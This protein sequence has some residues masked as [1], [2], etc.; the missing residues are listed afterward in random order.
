MTVSPP[1]N[2]PVV[3]RTRGE[4]EAL[5]RPRR[6]SG[7]RIGLVP[8][9]GALHVGHVA[10]FDEARAGCDL[11]V[12]SIFVNPMQFAPTEDLDRYPRS[13]DSD[14]EI[15]ARHGVDVVFAPSVEDV[16][17]GGTPQVTVDPG[18][19][20][21]TLEGAVRPGHFRGVLTV[22]AKLF[23]LV[24]PDV[25]VFGEKDYQQLVLIRRMVADLCQDIE[26]RAA[27]TVRE[28]D[29]LAFSSR[30]HYLSTAERR[31]ALALGRALAAG[32]A[33]GEAGAA[34]VLATAQ[35]ELE[36][37][38]DVEVDYLALRDVDL[39]EPPDHGPARL[40]VSATVGTT[41]LVDNV[42]V[43]LGRPPATS[44]DSS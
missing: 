30:N 18:P 29:G 34:T 11:V 21:E 26:V 14:L 3:V 19:L 2:A 17:P 33:V 15:C 31:T 6:D 40:L 7:A 25:A 36:G 22:V 28:P 39:G 43:E 37:G 32:A 10:L 13:F 41:H 35:Q 1:S 44:E 38:T 9:M 4:L 12:A 27:A 24:R 5:L 23:G 16:Y 42:A 20:A 8:T